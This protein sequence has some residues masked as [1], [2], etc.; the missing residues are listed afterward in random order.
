MTEATPRRWRVCFASGSRCDLPNDAGSAGTSERC[1]AEEISVVINDHV[2]LREG[3]ILGA[4]GKVMQRGVL[5]NS[6][7][8]CQFENRTPTV[9]AAARAGPIEIAGLVHRERGVIEGPIPPAKTGLMSWKSVQLGIG[10]AS[11]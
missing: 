8:I 9:L 11:R 2:A 3:P 5:P 7:R 10:P 6:V 4:V 1:S